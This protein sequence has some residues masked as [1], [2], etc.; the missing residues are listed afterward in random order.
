VTRVKRQRLTLASALFASNVPDAREGVTV[1]S[2]TEGCATAAVVEVDK[3]INTLVIT[4]SQAGDRA[5]RETLRARSD[6]TGTVF[7]LL[8]ID[9]LVA[10]TS[11]L[12]IVALAVTTL[13]LVIIT[14]LVL[15]I[16][17]GGLRRSRGLDGSGRSR[18]RLAAEGAGAP[19]PTPR[20]LRRRKSTRGLVRSTAALSRVPRPVEGAVSVSGWAGGALW[21]S[22]R[23][24]EVLGIP[25]GNHG[26]A[27]SL[28]RQ[29]RELT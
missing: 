18:G 21:P 20:T 23:K 28:P 11:V 29:R 14:I 19:V 6:I 22:A 26:S 24:A 8:G 27:Y 15:S 2:L 13:I 4:T 7:T 5:S 1:L 25:P 12:A 17:S 10:I 16:L 3:S 9:A